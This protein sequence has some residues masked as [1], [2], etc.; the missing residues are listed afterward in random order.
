MAS[1]SNFIRHKLEIDDFDCHLTF[2]R[3]FQNV[4]QNPRFLRRIVFG[5]EAS[6]S[7]N[8]KVNS[9]NIQMYAPKGNHPEF[10]YDV[11][12]SREELDV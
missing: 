7:M 6:L 10:T 8:G 12:N 5:D 1:V 4:S 11:K 3:W 9:Q 2:C